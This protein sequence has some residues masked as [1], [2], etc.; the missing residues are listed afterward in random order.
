M[1][2]IRNIVSKKLK[3]MPPSGRLGLTMDSST[4]LRFE[5]EMAAK[6]FLELANEHSLQGALQKVVDQVGRSPGLACLQIW[7][8]GDGDRC[9]RCPLR[10]Q[11]PDHRRCLHLIAGRGISVVEGGEPGTYFGD[12][13]ARIP[14][15]FGLVG[16]VASNRETVVPQKLTV[17]D[18]E[19]VGVDWTKQEGIR[20][21]CSGP[22]VFKGETLGVLAGY[23][24]DFAESEDSRSWTSIICDH[25]A[26]VMAN[27]LAFEEIQH[28]KAQLEL[29]NTYLQEEVVEARAFGELVGQSAA[30]RRIV[31]QI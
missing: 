10:E 24:R 28:L 29:Q 9:S 15:G 20:G 26:A 2:D 7:R 11:C 14:L 23:R 18:H 6:L 1:S 16:K 19:T 13:N 4:E 31:R 30:L 22:I 8:V 3:T 27:A 21:L 12:P 5:P 25:I 17:A